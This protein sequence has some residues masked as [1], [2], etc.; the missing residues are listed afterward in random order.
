MKLLQLTAIWVTLVLP[1]ARATDHLIVPGERVV[2]VKLGMAH[3]DLLRL[4]GAP[5]RQ[6]DLE[7]T[8]R[9]GKVLGE[10]GLRNVDTDLTGIRREDWITPL[11]LPHNLEENSSF[12]SDFLTVYVRGGRVVQIELRSS[13]F[14]TRDGASTAS[15]AKTLRKL[16]PDFLPLTLLYQHPS[17]MGIPATK[18]FVVYEDAQMVGIAWRYGVFGNLAPDPDTSGVLETIIVHSAGTPLI[19]D[20][21]G[22]SRFVWKDWPLGKNSNLPP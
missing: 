8:E 17:S 11:A 16:H 9:R 13:Q 7:Q 1:Q 18:H 5:H 22:G 3:A 14:K 10:T 15:S 19:P 21:D 2:E 20:A 4:L 12:M 6:D